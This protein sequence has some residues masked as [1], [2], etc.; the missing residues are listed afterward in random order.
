MS[1]Q[2]KGK[3]TKHHRKPKSIGGSNKAYNISRVPR[4]Q[5]ESWHNLFGNKTVP[6]IVA[7]LNEVWI[8]PNYKLIYKEKKPR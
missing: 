1:Q 5:H 6:E 3:L 4:G 2:D 7:I 8:D